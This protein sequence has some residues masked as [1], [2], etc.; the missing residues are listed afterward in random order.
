M[1]RVEQPDARARHAEG[2]RDLRG[3]ERE[4]CCAVERLGCAQEREHR[5]E[6]STLLAK[7]REGRLR[8]ARCGRFAEDAGGACGGSVLKLHRNAALELHGLAVL[9]PEGHLHQPHVL[10]RHE[11][12]EVVHAVVAALGMDHREDVELFRLRARVAKALEPSAIHEADAPIR[13]DA[14]NEIADTVEDLVRGDLI[15]GRARVWHTELL[16]RHRATARRAVLTD[17]GIL[18]R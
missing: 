1:L 18:R 7:A 4:E 2:G 16:R 15:E 3:D 17:A 14:L 13:P 12:L 10:A 9:C 5:L 8:A 6:E 11:A